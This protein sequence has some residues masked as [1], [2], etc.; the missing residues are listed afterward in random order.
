MKKKKLYDLY[1]N[2]IKNFKNA[3][4]IELLNA[5]SALHSS[6]TKVFSTS[7]SI[8]DQVI[9]D[10][11]IKLQS[12]VQIFTIDT[13][14]LPQHTYN[15]IEK[16]NKKY[17]IKIKVYFPDYH[18][19]EK[20]VSFKGP[21]FFYKFVDNRKLCCY[22]RKVKPLKRALKQADL[23]ITGLRK[24]QSVTRSD[25]K[26]FEWHQQFN[27]IKINPIYDWTTEQVWHYIKTNKI[28][29]NKLY[30]KGYLSIGCEPC[31]RSVKPGEPERS[32]RWWW[33]SQEHKE[34]GLHVVNGKLVRK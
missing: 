20:T 25:I 17:G 13:G 6:G 22:I 7:L 11:L 27:L 2:F 34:C 24:E 26:K 1:K 31:S 21:N 30:D 14:R 16:T 18:D 12:D 23:W 28:P 33:E 29:Y 4:I 3:D 15:L 19:I 32:G 9:T 10:L 8:E 5:V